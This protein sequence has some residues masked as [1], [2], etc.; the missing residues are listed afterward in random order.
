[1]T[2]NEW[3]IYSNQGATRNQPLDP[4]L[5]EAL[6]FMPELGLQMEVFSGGQ[7]GIGSGAPRVGSTRHDHGNAADVFLRQ[8]GQRLDWSNPQHQP[9]FA[10]VVRRA[11]AAGVTGFGAGQGYMQPG[12]MHIGFGN[13]GVWGAN[14]KRENAAEW[15]VNAYG[16]GAQAPA[17]GGTGGLSYGAAQPNIAAPSAMTLADMFG[18]PEVAP[19][20]EQPLF[21][22]PAKR[23]ETPEQEMLRRQALFSG[24]GSF[25]G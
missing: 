4:R 6:R 19:A 11:K 13:P 12:A 24:V 16:I 3:L 17:A 7:P 8:N 15:L 25:F 23:R 22:E 21:A 20:A 5:V 2:P 1:M 10:E 9:T 18:P 14:G